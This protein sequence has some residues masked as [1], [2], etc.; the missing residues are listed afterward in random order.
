M[1]D[2]ELVS[3]IMAQY[4]EKR[5]RAVGMRKQRINEVRQNFPRIAEIDAEIAR[6]GGE[7]INKIMAK[8]DKVKEYNSELKAKYDILYAEKNRIIRENGID[9][10]YEDYRYECSICS[11]TGFTPENKRCKCFEQQI[12]NDIY[13]RSDLGDVLKFEN[14]DTLSLEY[15]S[16]VNGENGV[17]ERDNI[18]RIVERAKKLCNNF[19]TERKGLLFY[20][21]TGLGKT[22][23]SNCIAK[24]LM[25]K[26]K[27][28]V[29]ARATRMFSIY[30]DYKFGREQDKSKIDKLYD[31][32]LLIIDDLGTENQSKINLAFLD[33]LLNERAARNKK[34]IISTNL[35]MDELAKIYSKRFTS[36]LF[37]YCIINKF[38]GSDI[39][40]QKL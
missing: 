17:S 9:P 30:E 18:I 26:G 38:Y 5:N 11:D 27:T 39:R 36:R 16:A 35:R 33:D 15:Y 24:E 31:A 25:D 19:D 34:L 28:V 8:P 13:A 29:Y 21:S 3:R 6:L 14:F 23:L 2:N 40:M 22:F 20:G 32:D 37:E 4:D 7:N 12:I 1:A 10:H